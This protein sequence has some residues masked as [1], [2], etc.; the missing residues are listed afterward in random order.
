MGVLNDARCYS[1]CEVFSGAIQ[2]HGAGTIFGEGK[3]TGGGGVVLELDPGLINTSPAYFQNFPF[4]QQLTSGSTTYTNAL[5]VG[6]TQTIRI[7]RYSDRDI[8]NLGIETDTI[9]R[10]WWSDLHPNS[11]TNTQS[12]RI[13]ARLART[14]RK[15]GQIEAAGIEE[16]TVFQDDGKT[17]SAHQKTTTN[18][19]T[20]PSPCLPL[21][22]PVL[23]VTAESP[24]L[25]RLQVIG[26]G[27]KYVNSIDSFTEAFFT[28][29]IGTNINIGLDVTL[30]TELGFDFL[31][32]SVKSSGN[33]ENFLLSS[34]SHDGTKTF[35]GISGRS[36]TVK[37]T[38]SFTI[39]PRKFFVSLMFT[40]DEGLG[41]IG[42]T[43]NT[44]TISAA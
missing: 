25:A 42:A 19:Q 4:S 14:G 15:N 12:Y 22:L 43:I 20:S 33:A 29:P 21:P 2:G 16:F 13:A 24:L 23:L 7:G 3:Q 44:F 8:E 40:S 11:T 38:F 35:N 36:M 5:S 31:Y 41:F 37:G 32:L 28:A 6:V 26:N 34:K 17:V 39:K 10:P 27:G 30:D 18:K 1:A 9:V